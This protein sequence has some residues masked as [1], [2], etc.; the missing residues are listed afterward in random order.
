MERMN[1]KARR[2]GHGQPRARRSAPVSFGPLGT[3]MEIE[4]DMVGAPRFELG[5]PSPPDWCANRA[6]L[7]SDAT[8]AGYS[9][10][11]SASSARRS[12]RRQLGNRTLGTS[13]DASRTVP[14]GTVPTAIIT[15]NGIPSF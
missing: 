8:R 2:S 7:R 1:A 4:E 9:Y 12:I 3:M 15:C 11:F 5:T 6:A 14:Y 13:N 10:G